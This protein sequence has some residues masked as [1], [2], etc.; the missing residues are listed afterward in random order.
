MKQLLERLLASALPCALAAS[1]LS[2][3]AAASPGGAAQAAAAEPPATATGA[4]LAG[5]H[6][7]QSEDWGNAARYMEQALSHDPGNVSLLRRTFLLQLG[8]GR[9]PQAVA[10]A[11]RL[12]ERDRTSHLAATVLAADDLAAN[13]AKQAEKRLAGAVGEDGLG[14][15]VTPLLRAWLDM[16]S[17]RPDAALKALA[18]LAV[19]PG[20]SALHDLQA[21]LVSDL[22]GRKADAAALYAKAS[23][24]GASLRV[25][26]LVANFHEREG[27][28]DEARR[29][30][31]RFLKDAPDPLLIEPAMKALGQGP[32]KPIVG[33]ARDGMAEALFELSSALHQEGAS[34]LALLYG[35]VALQLR[36]DFP[37]ARLMVGDVLA[38]RKRPVEAMAEYRQVGGDQGMRWV[39]RLRTAEL[40]Q[41]QKRDEEAIRLLE[42]MAAERP[43]RMDT[44]VAIG[45]LHRGAERFEQA[46]V[47]YDRAMERAGTAPSPRLWAIHYAR[48][49]ALERSKRWE[50]AEA[51]L[52]KALELSPEQ[53]YVL[54]YLGYS[55]VDRGEN[56]DRAKAMILRA[57]E[58]RPNDGY[59]V[60]S[61]GWVLYRLGDLDGAVANL[62]KAV[63]LKPLDAT[64]NDH[65]GDVYWRVGR[66]A[67]A[68]FQWERALMHAE[69]DKLKGEIR[70]KLASGLQPGRQ[71]QAAEGP[72][73]APR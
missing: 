53:P 21:A 67:E 40:L 72:G 5:R 7:Q 36:P 39:A 3:A 73:D 51:D 55:W 20:F 18:P 32:A 24:T 61:L 70:V 17:S 57:V 45:D 25:T 68:R 43:D 22:A 50:R 38:A 26:Q 65:L 13:R 9:I 23:E 59:I 29:V 10:L 71:Q 49:I 8:D 52:L 16:A 60:D 64:I 28:P 41:Q 31:E 63:E 69:D 34:E 54:N 1:L 27:R 2:P 37:L 12:A 4:Y 11:R 46:V 19:S 14:Q 48:G 42:E 47:A 30:Y 44:L 56:L 35:R 66:R 15:Y 6:A 58:L 33:N 62:E